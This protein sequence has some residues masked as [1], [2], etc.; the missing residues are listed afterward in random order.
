MVVVVVVVVKTN[1]IKGVIYDT[2]I[3]VVNLF[4]P[5]NSIKAPASS[6]ICR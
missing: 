6:V 5:P 2:L 1:I 3:T 4:L